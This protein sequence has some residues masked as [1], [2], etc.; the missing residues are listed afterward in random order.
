MHMYALHPFLPY[1]K[2]ECLQGIQHID[3]EQEH[4]R[5][6]PESAEPSA[7]VQACFK[8]HKVVK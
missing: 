2:N 5:A 3:P 6:D 8:G 7:K 1:T 4:A